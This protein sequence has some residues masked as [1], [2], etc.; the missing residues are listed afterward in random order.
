MADRDH[1][2]HAQVHP[3]HRYD[4]V[5]RSGTGKTEAG[6]WTGKNYQS[7]GPST[8]QVLAVLALLPIGGSLLA[9][10]GLTLTGTVIGLTVAT[11]VFVI[12]SP[13]LVP[14]AIAVTMVV[15]GFLSSGAFGVTGLSSLSY[16]FNRLRRVYSSSDEHDTEWAKRGMQDM[17]GY[18][19]QKTK[20]AGQKTKE[21]GQNMENKSHEQSVRT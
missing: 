20:E 3:Q 11:P 13:V 7:G 6:T 9:L 8:T 17:V 14:A 4:Q 15:L 18:A 19:G 21:A 5:V 1:P 2:L 10:A 12:F 16:V